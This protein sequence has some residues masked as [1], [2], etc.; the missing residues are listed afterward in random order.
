LRSAAATE[1]GEIPVSGLLEFWK[2]K[3]S[4]PVPRGADAIDTLPLLVSGNNT[5]PD[6]A[7]E[8]VAFANPVTIAVKE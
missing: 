5:V 1:L 3:A 7:A 2:L 8:P 6:G 4:V